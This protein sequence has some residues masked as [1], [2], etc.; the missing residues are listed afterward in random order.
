M[1]SSTLGN[2][3]TARRLVAFLFTQSN[4]VAVGA[5]VTGSLVVFTA[6]FAVI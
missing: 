6:P 4:R 5:F 1:P 3:A 2:V